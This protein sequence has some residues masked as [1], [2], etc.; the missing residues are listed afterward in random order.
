MTMSKQENDA[1]LEQ[2]RE[3]GFYR[4]KYRT[5]QK[6]WELYKQSLIKKY[7]AKEGKKWEFSCEH[8]QKIDEILKCIE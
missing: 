8:H 2:S 4:K 6:E 7:P 5:M 3:L 1:A